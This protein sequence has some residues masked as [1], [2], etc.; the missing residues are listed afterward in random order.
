MKKMLSVLLLLSL[1]QLGCNGQEKQMM[2]VRVLCYNIHHA[3]GTDGVTDYERLSKIITKYKPDI[4][5]LQEVDQKTSRV[6]GVDQVKVLGEKAGMQWRFGNAFSFGG[7]GYGQGVLSKLKI[8]S[9]ENTPYVMSKKLEPRAFLN[10][11]IQSGKGNFSFLNT[12]LSYEKDPDNKTKA[13]IDQAKQINQYIKGKNGL[14]LLVGD[15]NSRPE[16]ETYKQLITEWDDMMKIGGEEGFTSPSNNPRSRIDY[17]FARPKGK[18]RIV[19]ARILEASAASDH[20]GIFAVL[21]CDID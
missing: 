9:D 20:R 12:H 4:V 3:Q 21:E 1:M 19:E 8:I 2:R 7:G 15:F 13:S 5:G 17:I 10:V 14:M 16:S 18:W 6:K 11:G